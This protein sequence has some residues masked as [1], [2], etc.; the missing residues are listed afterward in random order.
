MNKDTQVNRLQ[1]MI[2]FLMEEKGEVIL[3]FSGKSE[4]EFGV[5]WSIFDL[6]VKRISV[7]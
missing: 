3:D 6:L 4:K 1:Q 5:G 7:I 2:D